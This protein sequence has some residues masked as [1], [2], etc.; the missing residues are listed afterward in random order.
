MDAH[1][2]L[3]AVALIELQL[4]HVAGKALDTL[5]NRFYVNFQR[6]GRTESVGALV[7]AELFPKVFLHVSSQSWFSEKFGTADLTLLC[8]FPMAECM[9][10]ETGFVFEGFVARRKRTWKGALFVV[11]GHVVVKVCFI[12]KH[13]TT[14]W[15]QSHGLDPLFPQVFV[16]VSLKASFRH[17]RKGLVTL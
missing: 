6:M 9:L 13:F 12:F 5:V 4:A 14:F 11:V 15:A 7:T 10:P 16:Q 8:F 2:F 17:G 3:Q 1:V